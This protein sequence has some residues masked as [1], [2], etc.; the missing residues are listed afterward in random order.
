MPNQTYFFGHHG[1]NVAKSSGHFKDKENII[2]R[3]EK[4]FVELEHDKPE[5]LNSTLKREPV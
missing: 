4:I 5:I 3:F 2:D 1:N